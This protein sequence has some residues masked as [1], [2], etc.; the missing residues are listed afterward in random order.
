[1]SKQWGK[2]L[3]NT[4]GSCSTTRDGWMALP[5]FQEARVI[6]PLGSVRMF[7]R[8]QCYRSKAQRQGHVS[9]PA[10][11]SEHDPK[12]ILPSF[13]VALHGFYIKIILVGLQTLG[14]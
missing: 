2:T 6:Y 1:M 14:R 9:P 7:K 11:S 10:R 5:H 13:I 8:P 4:A 3:S 12:I